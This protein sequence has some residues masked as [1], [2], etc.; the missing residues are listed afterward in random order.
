M[1]QNGSIRNTISETCVSSPIWPPLIITSQV[2]PMGDGDWT[3]LGTPQSDMH[4]IFLSMRSGKAL[5]PS[6][7][8]LVLDKLGTRSEHDTQR[9]TWGTRVQDCS[10]VVT[11]YQPRDM[12]LDRLHIEYRIEVAPPHP[13]GQGW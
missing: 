2:S 10:V 12:V 5:A 1:L 7:P 13:A 9:T 8:A 6:P 11:S 4:C 3:R